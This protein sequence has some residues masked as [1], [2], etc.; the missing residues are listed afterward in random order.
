[1]SAGAYVPPYDVRTYAHSH[2]S[3]NLYLRLRPYICPVTLLEWINYG[4]HHL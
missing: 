3:T 2:A 4:C 1:M